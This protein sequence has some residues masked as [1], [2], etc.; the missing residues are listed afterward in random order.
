MVFSLLFMALR[1]VFRLAP[2]Y[3]EH[4]NQKR[5]HRGLQLLAPEGASPVEEVDRVPDIQRRDLLGGLIHEYKC[6]A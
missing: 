2:A 3:G 5:W 1:A 4:Y 6:A